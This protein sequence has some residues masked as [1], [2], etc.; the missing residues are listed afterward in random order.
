MMKICQESFTPCSLWQNAI[1][2]I[3]QHNTGETASL[4]MIKLALD[5]YIV[6][7]KLK[8]LFQAK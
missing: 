5:N 7:S 1:Q 3:M 2:A 6:I 8:S 4:P